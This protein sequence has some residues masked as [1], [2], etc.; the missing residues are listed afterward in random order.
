[1]TSTGMRLL[2]VAGVLLA[3][4]TGCSGSPAPR[5]DERPEA[6]LQRVDTSISG[7][8]RQRT[9]G[10]IVAYHEVQDAVV[11]C[12]A[13]AGWTYAAPTFIDIYAGQATIPPGVGLGVFAALP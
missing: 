5:A 4:A 2:L 8:V 7:D 12:M 3:A 9:A 10:E 6:A 11:A 1:M 13:S